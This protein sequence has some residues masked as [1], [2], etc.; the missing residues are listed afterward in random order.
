MSKQNK[1][2]SIF[3]SILP[4]S[5]LVMHGYLGSYTRLIADDFCSMYF[6][7]NLGLLRS[8]WFWRL[9]WSGRYSAFAIDWV[10]AKLTPIHSLPFVTSILLILWCLFAIIAIFLT[11]R[12]IKSGTWNWIAAFLAG[13]LFVF[14]V[15]SLSP[16]PSQSLYWWNGMRSYS[17]PLI[18]L[19]LAFMIF[20]ARPQKF[21][22]NLTGILWGAGSFILLF[23]IGGLGET[24]AVF[25]FSTLFFLIILRLVSNPIKKEDTG[26][27]IYLAGIIG[28]ILSLVVII[29]APG[30]AIRQALNPAPDLSKLITISVQSYVDFIKNIILSPEKIAGLFGT[31]LLIIL[32][33][34]LYPIFNGKHGHA[35]T[36]TIGGLLL[37][38][39]CF[40]PGVYGYS[41]APPD[42]TLIIASFGLVAG[43][44]YA[45][46]SIGQ[47]H[48]I[49]FQTSKI[50]YG[51]TTF[52]ILMLGFSTIV[53]FQS[54][55][56][57]AQ[58][59]I[60][61]AN[62][63]DKNDQL[64]RDAKSL[65]KDSVFI[66]NPEANNW[67]GL[68]VLN[69]NP[70]FWVNICY[71]KYYGISVFGPNPDLVLP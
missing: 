4:A 15:L 40:P 56:Q 43:L 52:A 3:L 47:Q 37:S 60:D 7:E 31:M 41:E 28:T 64:I 50:M 17:L 8:I 14:I 33:G 54:L 18:G 34:S 62:T 49:F 19:T 13:L 63:W 46:F 66:E 51:V 65:Q 48:A 22:S 39:A 44:F 21:A 36:A 2:F 32:I 70:K 42:R 20:Q 5:V 6:A 10:L 57:Q 1:I 67:T 35:L 24:Y 53:Q 38:L 11:L 16:T 30:N 59:Y 58:T 68:N 12:S 27:L 45:S 69:D 25:Q 26:L 29:S 55:K 61:Y 9:N 71:S 23:I